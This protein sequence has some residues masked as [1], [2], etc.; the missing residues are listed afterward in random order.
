MR[1]L[2]GSSDFISS[3]LAHALPVSDSQEQNSGTI[4]GLFENDILLVSVDQP[5]VEDRALTED[6]EESNSGDVNFNSETNL[7]FVC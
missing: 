5:R 3:G 6:I 7:Y 1:H 4:P 2:R